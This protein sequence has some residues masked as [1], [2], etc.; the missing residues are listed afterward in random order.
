MPRLW[1]IVWSDT[2]AEDLAEI[3]DYIA[4]ES[5]RYADVVVS[6]LYDA[7]GHLAR[8]PESGRIVP[9]LENPAV[10]EIVRGS[11]RI[12]YELREGRV[13]ISTVFHGSRLFPGG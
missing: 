2:A 7:V 4:R 1:P 10:R 12:V 6:R 8:F 3:R 13:E 11:Y 5:P 9:E